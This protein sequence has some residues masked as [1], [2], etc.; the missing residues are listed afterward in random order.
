MSESGCFGEIKEIKKHF[1]F[2]L[3]LLFFFFAKLIL[4]IVFI[5]M[6]IEVNPD[7]FKFFEQV[8]LIF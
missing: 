7:G 6:L 2:H 3:S 5:V 4:Y 1:R 8:L